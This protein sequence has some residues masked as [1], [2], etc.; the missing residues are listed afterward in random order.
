MVTNLHSSGAGRH[1]AR[2]VSATL[3]RRMRDRMGPR[4]QSHGPACLVIVPLGEVSR[5]AQ[6]ALTAALALGD[7][8]VAVSVQA[9]PEK[10]RAL[11]DTWDRWN[12]GV[13]LE[14]IDSP[15][16]SL[17]QPMVAYVRREAGGGREIAVLIPEVEPRHRRYRILQNRRGL[18]LATVLRAR[19][20]AVVCMMPYRLSV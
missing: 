3:A 4:N 9:E 19:T 15:H 20:D 12:P 5:L 10:A 6:R 18:L 1:P 11:Q 14:I 8:V 2:L 13:R 16:R 7:E 17:V